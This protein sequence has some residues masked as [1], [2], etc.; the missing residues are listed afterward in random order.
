[1]LFSHNTETTV[2]LTNRIFSKITKFLKYY[3]DSNLAGAMSV[4]VGKAL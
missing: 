2:F 4:G 1:M 3:Y